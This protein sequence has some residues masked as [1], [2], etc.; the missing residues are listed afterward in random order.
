MGNNTRKT[1]TQK[2]ND[3]ESVQRNIK[4]AEVRIA[5]TIEDHMTRILYTWQ[6]FLD[7]PRE[8]LQPF[9]DLIG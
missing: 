7:A 4:Q 9:Q 6:G 3:G 2:L 5:S 1:L 8:G